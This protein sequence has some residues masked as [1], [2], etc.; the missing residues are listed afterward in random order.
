[1]TAILLFLMLF[2]PDC[3]RASDESVEAR[4]GTSWHPELISLISPRPTIYNAAFRDVMADMET[5]WP[6]EVAKTRAGSIVQRLRN[7]W[8]SH[9]CLMSD[10][11]LYSGP[12]LRFSTTSGPQETWEDYVHDK[13]G[14]G[15]PPLVD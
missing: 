10:T 1:M 4:A 2:L 12:F 9:R 3:K 14:Y 13:V 8:Q 7:F 15:I 5:Q 11:K 6:F